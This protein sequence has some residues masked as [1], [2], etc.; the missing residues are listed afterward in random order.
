MV[1]PSSFTRLNAGAYEASAD[2]TVRDWDVASPPR[3]LVLESL[4]VLKYGGEV[5]C[6][7]FS[8]DGQRLVSG[9][10]DHA[11]RVWE[12]PSGRL[13]RIIRIP[14]GVDDEGEHLYPAFPYTAFTRLNVGYIDAIMAA[15]EAHLIRPI[16]YRAL[17]SLRLEK[18]YRAWGS[19]ITPND[20][21]FEAG[22]GWAVKLKGGAG[23]VGRKALEAVAG[24]ALNKRFA[25]FTLDDPQTVLVGRETILR[26]G[27][28][29]GYLTSGGFG[30]TIGKNIGFGYV[31][32]ADGVSDEFLASGRYE[33]VVANQV[34][35]AEIALSPLWDPKGGRIK[36]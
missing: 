2:G 29:V 11:L 7:A 1:S 13:L 28:P 3:P 24:Q 4:S 5:E 17:E 23:F 35:P 15:G 27:E 25:G 30:Y 10:D 36:A 32:N 26:N 12:L 19:D 8:P 21:P 34:F 31:R 9:H 18:G 6:L 33:L 22:L 20:T 16:G 14:I